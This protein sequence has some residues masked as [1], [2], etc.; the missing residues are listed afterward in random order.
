MHA[1]AT[2]RGTRFGR[3]VPTPKNA[4]SYGTSQQAV[5]SDENDTL[6][7]LLA[8]LTDGSA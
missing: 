8:K 2:R 1:N 7:K 5:N 4:G 3:T 6:Q